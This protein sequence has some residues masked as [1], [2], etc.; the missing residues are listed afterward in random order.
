MKNHLR[1]LLFASVALLLMGAAASLTTLQV[2]TGNRVVTGNIVVGNGTS[3]SATGNGTI[4]ATSSSGNIT[5]NIAAGTAGTSAHVL[6]GTDRILTLTSNSTSENSLLRFK[7]G[8]SNKYSIGFNDPGTPQMIFYDDANSAYL[9]SWN[10][11]GLTITNAATI[12]GG[13]ALAAVRTATA[14]LNFPSTASGA[15]ADLTV[16]VTGAA[17]N[18]T[19]I[20]G[21]P[22]GSVTSTATYTAWVSSANTVTVRF[23]PKATEDP[24]SGTFRV[25]VIS[26]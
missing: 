24:A 16:T 13:S 22:A 20:V 2:Y 9:G 6:S 1:A 4:T 5:G 15:V 12:G 25:T 7:G 26:F 10:A 14:T 17:A 3:I 18:D 19:V 11:T 8:A 23:S 21:P